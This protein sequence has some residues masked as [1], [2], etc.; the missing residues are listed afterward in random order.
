MSE[1]VK[2]TEE[3]MNELKVIQQTY[4]EVQQGL[5]QVSITRLRLQQQLNNLDVHENKLI[6]TFEN[7]QNAESKFISVVTEKYG[8]GTLDPQTGVFALNKSE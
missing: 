4:L 8:N 5:G 1:Q 2:F 3:E 6:E 7:N